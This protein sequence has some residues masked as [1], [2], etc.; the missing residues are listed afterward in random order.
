MFILIGVLELSTFHLFVFLLFFFIK[1]KVSPNFQI[2][3]YQFGL[4]CQLE[5]HILQ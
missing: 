2:L 1:S 5:L 3:F 4:F